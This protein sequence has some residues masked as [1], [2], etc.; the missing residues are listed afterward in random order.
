MSIGVFTECCST[1]ILLP[2]AAASIAKM[3][4][5]SNT[6]TNKCLAVAVLALLL[7]G[8]AACGDGDGV[9][10]ATAPLSTNASGRVVLD[11]ATSCG[12]P[13]FQA[14]L[15]TQI[16]AAR[17]QARSCG[18]T[19]MPAAGPVAWNER[20]FS[21]AARHSADMA[22]HG[23]FDHIGQDGRSPSQR[24]SA[25]GYQWTYAGENIAAGQT[26]VDSVMASWLASPGHCENLMR[27]PYTEVGVA[28]VVAPTG[29]TYSRYWTM[30]L[31]RP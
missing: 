24:I 1:H 10:N 28:C 11:G 21:A 4:G 18:N 25:E 19:A 30:N 23:Y 31:G 16:N 8:L 5:M 3:G 29:A 26:S 15:L 14:S 13:D 12:L 6:N 27:G 22:L 17:A 9:S 20:L 2:G 7:G